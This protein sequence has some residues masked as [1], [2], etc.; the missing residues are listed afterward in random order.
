M[1][2][3]YSAY[4]PAWVSLYPCVSLYLPACIL[5]CVSRCWHAITLLAFRVPVNILVMSMPLSSLVYVYVPCTY[6]YNLHM[7]VT[8]PPCVFHVRASCT[9]KPTCKYVPSMG[10]YLCARLCLIYLTRV[11]AL[12]VCKSS[13]CVNIYVLSCF[14]WPHLFVC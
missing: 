14:L 12:Q 13:M 4:V 9:R 6:T 8:S 7:P 10:Q 2:C 1:K 3:L 11:P 5:D